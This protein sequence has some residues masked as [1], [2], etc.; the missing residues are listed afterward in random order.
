VA[1]QIAN[2]DQETADVTLP[3][4]TLYKDE[5]IKILAEPP[6]IRPRIFRRHRTPAG[7]FFGGLQDATRWWP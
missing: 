3:G 2:A 5:L 4:D 7:E 6:R 1:V